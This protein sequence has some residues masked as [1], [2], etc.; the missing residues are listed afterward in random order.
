MTETALNY[1]AL[2]IV[3]AVV[4]AGTFCLRSCLILLFGWIGAVPARLEAALRF[5]PAAVLAALAIPAFVVLDGTVALTVTNERLVAGAAGTLVAWRTENMLLTIA[6][7]MT[8]LW[9]IA[10]LV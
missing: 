7:G 10:F 3:I 4:A 1:L 8:V 5:V 9:V 2:W 6:V